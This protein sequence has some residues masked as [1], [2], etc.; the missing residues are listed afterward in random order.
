MTDDEKQ[1]VAFRID[2]EGFD[3]TFMHYSDFSEISDSEFHK[4]RQA[5]I[6]AANALQEYVGE[7][8]E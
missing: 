7:L 8:E 6:D 3:Y 1:E 5:Y 2:Q 4:L